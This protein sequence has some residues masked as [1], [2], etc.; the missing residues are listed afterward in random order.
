MRGDCLMRSGADSCVSSDRVVYG[1]RE[2]PVGALFFLGL[3]AIAVPAVP[4]AWRDGEPLPAVIL[5]FIVAVFSFLALRLPFLGVVIE[6]E[7][8][9][10][11]QLHRSVR[12]PLADAIGVRLT[13]SSAGGTL[14]LDCRS[15]DSLLLQGMDWGFRREVV[16][17]RPGGIIDRINGDIAARREA[18]RRRGMAR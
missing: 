17:A 11:R 2:R 7:W 16:A 10:V 14:V 8:T 18:S 1:A 12:V 15:R 5:A 4:A 9:T 13:T 6:D 3:A